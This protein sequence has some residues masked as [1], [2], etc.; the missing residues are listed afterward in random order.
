MGGGA[1]RLVG[2]NLAIAVGAYQYGV[3]GD[4]EGGALV[5]EMEAQA[6]LRGNDGEVVVAAGFELLRMQPDGRFGEEGDVVVDKRV[7]GEGVDGVADGVV[8]DER[9]FGSVGQVVVE[10]HRYFGFVGVVALVGEGEGDTCL[11]VGE[12]EYFV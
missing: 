5:L 2:E 6:A 10:Y 9:V 7:D 4:V 11:L 3:V 8:V 12:E 1:E